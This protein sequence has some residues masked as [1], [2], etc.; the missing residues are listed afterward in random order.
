MVSI[1]VP[2]YNVEGYLKRCI[3]SILKQTKRD[4]EIILVDDGSTDSSGRLCDEFAALDDR[5]LVIHKENG[6]LTSAWKA[7][8]AV[9]SGEF[10]GFVDSDDWI[11]E[12]MFETLYE[13]AIKSDADLTI[14]GLVYEFEDGKREIKTEAS[15]LTGKVYDREAIEREIYPTLL[16]DGSFFGRTIQPARVTKLYRRK[17][18]LDNLLF[19]KESVSIGED[20]QLTFPV[21]CDAKTV[22]MLE[23]YFPYHY[24]INDKSMTGRHD[25]NYIG[26]IA[27]TMN[28]LLNIN[29]QKQVYDFTTQ[30]IND[31]LCLAILGIKSEILKNSKAGVRAV[32]KNLKKIFNMPELREALDSYNMPSL[33]IAERIYIKLIR[34]KMYRTC[35]FITYI[36]FTVSSNLK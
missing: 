15:K 25:P 11:D 13:N 7:G 32:I 24:W 10:L 5:I 36:F 20:L 16:S 27:E 31:F 35:Y 8:A 2:V 21:L 3:S 4:I 14:C 23:N 1:I 18:V 19:C 6:G 28:Q 34:Y 9:S 17:I 33:G 22:C 12:D 30:I 29:V 26:K